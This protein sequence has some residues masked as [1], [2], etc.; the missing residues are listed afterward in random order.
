MKDKNKT[1]LVV[2]GIIFVITMSFTVLGG[3]KYKEGYGNGL[4]AKE[5]LEPIVEAFNTQTFITS[6]KAA[7]TTIKAEN[8]SS[9][10]LVT[11]SKGINTTSFLFNYK[12]E[13]NFR[14]V[15]L[16]YTTPD[17]TAA[18]VVG[19]GIIEATATANGAKDGDVFNQYSFDEF[20]TT[21]LADGVVLINTGDNYTIKINI[22]TNIVENLKQKDVV[23]VEEE[24][25]E[26][27]PD[28]NENPDG[29]IVYT[30]PD[31]F[32]Q[33]VKTTANNKCTLSMDVLTKYTNAQSFI[34]DLSKELDIEPST[35]ATESFTYYEITESSAESKMHYVALENKAKVILIR[36]KADANNDECKTELNSF[37]STIS[38]Q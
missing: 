23:P 7:G 1:R 25:F 2:W 10:I 12:V 8:K 14:L 37:I 11:Y 32:N 35:Y 33:N 22:K 4:Q 17:K 16:D 15:Q 29:Y 18:E 38:L 5:D 34:N 24:Q 9:Y 6:Y 3:V 28:E 21:S 36:M 19:R 26:I 31:G 20:R 30:I 13:G 27:I